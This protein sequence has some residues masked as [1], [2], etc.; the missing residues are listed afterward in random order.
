[1]NQ[2]FKWLLTALAAPRCSKTLA[3]LTIA[4]LAL[5][6]AC[7]NT[8]ANQNSAIISKQDSSGVEIVTLEGAPAPQALQLSQAHQLI[9]LDSLEIDEVRQIRLGYLSSTGTVVLSSTRPLRV[10]LIDSTGAVKNQFGRSGDGPGEYRAVSSLRQLDDGKI[11]IFDPVNR[12]VTEFQSD[13]RVAQVATYSTLKDRPN[14]A[15]SS[16][17]G[18]FNDG[19]VL[20]RAASPALPAPG[21]SRSPF[22]FVRLYPNDS[23]NVLPGTFNGDEVFVGT[24]GPGGFAPIGVPPFGYKTLA[25]VCGESFV[26]AENFG[27]EVQLRNANGALQRVVRVSFP[28]QLLSANDYTEYWKQNG[29]DAPSE[30]DVARIKQMTHGDSLPLLKAL[31]CDNNGNSLIE[32]EASPSD[33]TRVLWLMTPSWSEV[34][35]YTIPAQA[36][37]LSVAGNK[38]LVAWQ[39]SETR[40]SLGVFT[41]AP[42]AVD[43]N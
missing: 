29:L 13:G 34:E 11:T 6:A 41:L 25:A 40:V 31:H 42:G 30:D 33:S 12:R 14:A 3:A 27:H 15:P 37:V 7:E 16:P 18:V 39:V 38:V 26:L 17:A 9:Q 10:V 21:L 22:E 20:V 24:P 43:K 2:S 1:M 23:S 4:G 5:F 36:R 32:F 19:S 28:S 35:S 8:P